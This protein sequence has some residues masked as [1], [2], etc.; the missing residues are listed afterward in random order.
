[1]NKGVA[2]WGGDREGAAE[3]PLA[4]QEVVNDRTQSADRHQQ[5]A[6]D[7]ARL[8]FRLICFGGADHP[9]AVTAVGQSTAALKEVPQPAPGL[10]EGPMEPHVAP[11]MR[12]RGAQAVFVAGG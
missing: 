1:M 9:R 6:G 5:G 4:L 2:R 8:P 7:I 10:P 3:P 11:F 12:Q